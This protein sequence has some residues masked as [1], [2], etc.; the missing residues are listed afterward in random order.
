METNNL[1][2]MFILIFIFLIALSLNANFGKGAECFPKY[3][4]EEWSECDDG[5]QSRTCKDKTCGRRDIIERKF[6]AVG[7]TPKIECEEWGQCIYT[8]KIEDLL[9]GEIKFGG[10]RNR[11]CKDINGCVENFVEE[12]S[13]EESFKLDLVKV[14][15]CNEEFLIISDS[16]SKKRIAEINLGRWKKNVLDITFIQKESEYCT[17]CYNGLKDSDEERVDCGGECK[18]C[19]EER[20]FP[21]LAI[22]IISLWILSSL[23]VSLFF[24]EYFSL[25][26]RIKSKK[27]LRGK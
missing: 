5:L 10:Y 25:K 8:D 12:S 26:K 21:S 24:I 23:F 15:K 17:S 16:L 4:C 20:E 3:K 27:R 1:K 14:K 9:L 11:V 18:Q 6:C 19:R 22:F 2:K 7:C 13:C